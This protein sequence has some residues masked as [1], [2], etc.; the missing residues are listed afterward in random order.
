MEQ[1]EEPYCGSHESKFMWDGGT[2]VECV[3]CLRMRIR[4]YEDA[5]KAIAGSH[6]DPE[7][8]A[9]EVLEVYADTR[10]CECGKAFAL[11]GACAN[12]GGIL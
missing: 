1:P 10:K 2:D 7:E 9:K 11:N 12:C 6:V 8:K 4:D 3:G 5:L